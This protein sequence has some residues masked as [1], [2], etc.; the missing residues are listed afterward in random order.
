M[1]WNLLVGDC[2]ERMAELD[3]ASI[4]AIVCDPPYGLE[5]MGKGWDSFRVDDRAVPG[6]NGRETGNA[7]SLEG[8]EYSD[9][10]ATGAPARRARVAYGGGKRATTSRCEGCGKRDQFRK[11]H[12]GC[13]DGTNWRTEIIDPY[14]APPTMLAF[15]NWCRIWATEAMRILK[16]GGHLLAFGG[17]RTYHRLAAGIEDAGFEV[18]DS[19]HWM[20]GNG[21]PKAL[22]VAKAMGKLGLPE[23]E[24]WEG[25]AT[26]LKPGHEPIVVARKPLAGTV[27]QT[28]LA[29]GTGALNID[30]CRVAFASADDERAAKEPNQ[31]AKWGSGP[32]DNA[33]YGADARSRADQGDYDAD[34][35]FP[36]NVVFSHGPGCELLG[37]RRV[38]TSTGASL[39]DPE[40]HGIYG[41]GFPRGDG[42]TVGYADA[43]GLEEVE[44]WACQPGCPV[45]QL[46]NQ[47]GRLHAPGSNGDRVAAGLYTP[48]PRAQHASFSQAG[49]ASRFYPVFR[50]EPKASR[51]EREAG[52][53][54][55]EGERAN[56]HPTVK[57]ID[58]MRWLVRLVTPPGGTVLDPFTGSGSTG[59]ASVL[60][61]F[62]FIGCEQDAGYAD[63]IRARIQWWSEQPQGIDT[64]KAIVGGKA[65]DRVTTS[66]QLGLL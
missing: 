38:P 57:P 30:A 10:D 54:A 53:G 55:P 16:P 50:Y 39:G 41:G 5:F 24:E 61:G 13:P 8:G 42:R 46:D 11:P 23:A 49:G 65:R 12:D 21:F 22:N 35:R 66:G 31:H 62:D 29:H 45:A 43:D 27:A 40:G 28:V 44:E 2:V 19:I 48:G 14:S 64:E 36:P 34:A 63:L 20:Y 47:T 6:Y 17:T 9:T 33:V 51:A 3:E 26:A 7:G 56:D 32:R 1:T 15:Q 52:L 60:E 37:T 18:R 59:I 58:L 4:D 25:W